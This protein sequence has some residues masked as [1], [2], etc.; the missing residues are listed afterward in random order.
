MRILIADY[1][2]PDAAEKLR[3][4]MLAESLANAGHEVRLLVSPA[5]NSPD[6]SLAQL[7]NE[8]LAAYRDGLRQQLDA[9]VNDFDPNVAQA[10]EIG[11]WGQLLVESGVPFVLTANTRDFVAMDRD[12]RLAELAEQAAENAGR[13]LAANETLAHEVRRRYPGVEGRVIVQPELDPI[14]E[15][16]LSPAFVV[17]LCNLYEQVIRERLGTMPP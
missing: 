7:S 8:Q 13:I 2:S 16:A 12:P 1:L 14:T 17:T 3:T 11:M 6:F 10:Q 5:G 15:S 9:A 4:K